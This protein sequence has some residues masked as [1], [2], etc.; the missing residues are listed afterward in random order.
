MNNTELIE[1]Y[2]KFIAFEKRL[3]SSSVKSYL[4][5]INELLKLMGNKKLNSYSIEDIRKNHKQL[6]L[7]EEY[8]RDREMIN[9]I[10]KKINDEDIADDKKTIL[11][12]MSDYD[13]EDLDIIS[14]NF[15]LRN[16]L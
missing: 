8:V 5:D 16:N 9:I 14:Y 10:S 12:S 6:L 1:E 15:W 11:S 4:R 7:D 3:S 2:K 13:S